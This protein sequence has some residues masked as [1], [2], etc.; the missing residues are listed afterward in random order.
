MSEAKGNRA[1]REK[2]RLVLTVRVKEQ[3]PRGESVACM[4]HSH[5]GAHRSKVGTIEAKS[6]SDQLPGNIDEDNNSHKNR[7]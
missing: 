6:R 7:E 2:A 5:E 1:Q 3:S 4:W